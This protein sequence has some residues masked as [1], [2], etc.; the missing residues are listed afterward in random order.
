MRIMHDLHDSLG[1]QLTAIALN[2]EVAAHT[3]K[4]ALEPIRTAQ[5]LARASLQQIR[6]MARDGAGGATDLAA[7]LQQLARELPRPRIHLSGADHAGALPPDLRRLLLQAIQE[8]T[9][10]AIRHGAAG[11]LWIEFSRHPRQLRMLARDDGAGAASIEDGFGI[12]GIRRRVE[13]H[14]G[15]VSFDGASGRGFAV[16][17]EIPLAPQ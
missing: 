7:E 17:I 2:L 3:D 6:A 5:Q 9:S 8:L 14:G 12:S 11:N 16:S 10:N 1:H 15:K 13:Q 4:A